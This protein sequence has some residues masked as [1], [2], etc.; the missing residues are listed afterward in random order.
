M[1]TIGILEFKELINA[2]LI[3]P[4]KY[5]GKSIILWNG[6][7]SPESI[8]N[9]I[10]EECCVNYNQTHLDNQVWYKEILDMIQIPYEITTSKVF[11]DREDMYGSKDRGI[12]LLARPDTVS[13]QKLSNEE[14][15]QWLKFINSHEYQG[16]TL[17]SEWTI[18]ACAHE[19]DYGFTE[20]MF[21]KDC[22]LYEFKPSVDEWA[23]WM[24]DKCDEKDLKPL[25]AFIKEKK[26]TLDLYYWNIALSVL[27]TELIDKDYEVLSQLSYDDFE[28]CLRFRLPI[29]VK[30]SFPYNQLWEFVQSYPL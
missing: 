24:K 16:K 14:I 29:G 15:S 5:A 28:G 10:I 17:S 18:F 30:G 6:H 25:V 23:E 26:S 13:L 20:D 22:V 9:Q 1:I 27:E 4:E 8:E 19:N 7:T 12:L 3:N 2:C 11:C 21:S